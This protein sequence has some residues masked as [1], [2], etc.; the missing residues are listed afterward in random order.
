[1]KAGK[2]A[3]DLGL[4]LNA[5]HGL[6]YENVRP[7]AMIKGMN[8]LNIGFSIISKALFVGIGNAVRQM[9]KL[10]S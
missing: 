4:I 8:E 10:I 6:D 9:K 2:L 1:M 5:G 7:V 3:I